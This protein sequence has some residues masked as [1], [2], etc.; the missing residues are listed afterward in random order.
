MSTKEEEEVHQ[1]VNEDLAAEKHKQGESK[2]Y[3][4]I[5]K[6]QLEE[7]EE[8][9]DKSAGHVLMNSLTAGLEIG[10]SFF[11]LCA[12]FYFLEGK[13]SEEAQFKYLTLVYPLGFI[14]VVLGRS[15]LFT[16]QT[17]L[18]TLPVLNQ[19]RSFREL[20][21]LWGL[22]IL[23]NLI[24]GYLIALVLVWIGPMLHI[25]DSETIES[26][27]HHIT[28]F[29]AYVILVSAVL[30]GWLMGLLSWLCSSTRDTISKI[31]IIFIITG[32]MAFTGLHHSIVGSIEVFSGVISG[33]TIGWSD[34]F[35]FQ[36][37]ALL[38]NALGG[39]IFVALL[40]YRAYQYNSTADPD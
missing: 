2:S 27:A 24:G 21:R 13:V 4:S 5:L 35:S 20:M 8:T 6:E 19:K 1:E 30:A 29:P 22:V 34:Y 14:L 40:R 25:Y 33:D 10:F 36:G 31:V 7:G 12:L 18:L 23:G 16:E 26:I 9:Y 15:L 11:M 38:G 32:I 3:G 39:A 17:S 28:D 37:M